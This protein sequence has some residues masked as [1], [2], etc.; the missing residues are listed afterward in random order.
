MS[1]WL[2]E[3]RPGHSLE[4]WRTQARHA[5]R[6]GLPPEEIS[7]SS[8]ETPSL[9]PLPPVQ[10]APARIAAPRVPA[11]LPD[12]ASR[13]LCHHDDQRHG[14][15]Y[16]L[17]WRIA[18]GERGLMQTP[19]DADLRRVQA[20]AQTVNRDSHKMKA[21]VRFREVPGMPD[22]FIAW[23][24]PEFRI[25]ERVAPFFARRFAGMHWSILTPQATAHWDGEAL[26]FGDGGHR[27]D[28]PAE[29]AREAL[30]CT[31]YRHVF[32]PARL[33]TAQ[34]RKEMPQKF[35]KHLPE[36]AT[37]PSLVRE[38][39]ERV[40]AMHERAPQA[41]RRRIPARRTPAG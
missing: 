6:A 2:A 32:N 14:L 15:L 30:W 5:L 1:R 26:R 27:A 28:A 24:E 38:A 7:W 35:W 34:M 3:V 31:Y 22:H 17:L 18:Q 4:A 25:L 36:A 37:I 21:F 40:Q 11:M 19:T 39:G 9:L 16:R 20:L 29:D 33:N 8:G 10:Q 13:A 23:Y 12:L 41:P